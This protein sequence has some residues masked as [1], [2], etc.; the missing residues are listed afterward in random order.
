M[1][2]TVTEHQCQRERCPGC[3]ATVT[4]VLPSEV[5]SSAFGP[6]LQAAIVTLSVR[7]RVSRRD[8]VELCEQLFSSRIS[9]GTIDA[10]LT[11]AGDALAEPYADLLDRVRGADALN[12]DETGW[13]LKGAQRA[14]WG[15][16]TDRHAVFAIAP[17]RHEDHARDLLGDSQAIVTSDRWWAYG[18]LP[19]ARRQVCWSHLQRD[20]AA[21][22]DGLAAEKDLGEAGLR[23]CERA[24]LGVGDL[25]AHRRPRRAQ[26][27]HPQAAPRAQADPRPPRRQ[28]RALPLHT[29]LRAQPAEDLAGTM[30]LRRRSTAC[31][32]PTTT[33]NAGSAAQSS[34]ASSAS[35]ANPKAANDA[36]NGCSR[37]TP[38]AACNTA[39]CTPTSSTCSP[40]L[41]AAIR[42][43]CWPDRTD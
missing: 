12:I 43:R 5:A 3:A 37:S 39:R 9:T 27:P 11:R 6:R 15:A 10:I 38:P 7:N 8:V 26:A 28:G 36:S 31:S 1:A 23:I 21:H 33:P 16:F 18:H 13:R 24:V 41:P 4:A 17:S 20:F 40:P 32:R 22:A 30:D 42:P 2:V 19:I 35:A 14:L 25:P 29:T 34:R